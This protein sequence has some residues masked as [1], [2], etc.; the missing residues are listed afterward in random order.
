MAL[1]RFLVC[2]LG[3]LGQHCV[4]ALKE[5]GVKIIAIE[6]ELS[7]HQDWE[8]TELPTLLEKLILGDCRHKNILQQAQIAQCRAALIVTT[9]E[10]VNTETA[11]AIRQLNPH[12]RLVVRSAQ[13]NL[14][15]LLTE[16]LG[17]LIAY[18]ATRLPAD[19]F[20][21]SALGTD[22]LASITVQGSKMR[23]IK[24]KLDKNDPWCHSRY[25]N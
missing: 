18:E 9:S 21:I 12:T 4:V 16:K 2:G 3:S 24:R 11:I 10:K 14:N 8:I 1:D 6:R 19:T 22:I 17:N 7:P 25:M 5:F 13:E 15:E 20:A 23:I